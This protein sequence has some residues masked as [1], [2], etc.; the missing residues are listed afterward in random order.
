[1]N[2]RV[3]YQNMAIRYEGAD[4]NAISSLHHPPQ[5]GPQPPLDG[6]SPS[7]A[8]RKFVLGCGPALG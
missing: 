3:R 4:L 6:Y 8:D 5:N 2:M 1:M 7:G